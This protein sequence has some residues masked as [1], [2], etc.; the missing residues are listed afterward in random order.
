MTHFWAL[1]QQPSIKA[2][3]GSWC[4]LWGQIL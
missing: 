1:W 3:C 4:H 2:I